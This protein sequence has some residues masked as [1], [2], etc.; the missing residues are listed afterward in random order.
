MEEVRGDH[1]RLLGK[2]I[3][4]R[5]QIARLKSG[6]QAAIERRHSELSQLRSKFKTQRSSKDSEQKLQAQL[7]EMKT[8]A[9]DK[10]GALN[11]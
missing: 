8:Q 3:D 1:A 4:L 7:N 5:F 6:K 10:V 11:R 2:R 9:A